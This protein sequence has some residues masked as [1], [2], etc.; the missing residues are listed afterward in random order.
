MAHRLHA[1][2]PASFFFFFYLKKP[3]ELSPVF[4]V[5]VVAFI[6]FLSFTVFVLFCLQNAA[7]HFWNLAEVD[8]IK[9]KRQK[10]TLG[11]RGSGRILN[12]AL[13]YI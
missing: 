7:T 11:S 5:V 6:A 9:R 2:R 13:I 4:F 1:N 10:Y 8:G 12:R 3:N